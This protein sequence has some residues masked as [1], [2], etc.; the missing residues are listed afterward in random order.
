MG[1]VTEVPGFVPGVLSKGLRLEL[2]LVSGEH[3]GGSGFTLVLSTPGSVLRNQ[4][5]VV[6]S[7]GR[8][9]DPHLCPW[10]S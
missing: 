8:G 5:A 7:Q 10:E 4:R 1:K 6:C 2:H 3:L 9:Q